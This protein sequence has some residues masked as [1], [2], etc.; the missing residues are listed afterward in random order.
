MRV[1]LLLTLVLLVNPIASMA[2]LNGD[3]HARFDQ[4]QRAL[5]GDQEAIEALSAEP[6]ERAFFHFVR[7]AALARL[8]QTD[9]AAEAFQ[10]AIRL[11][12]DLAILALAE[13]LKG[14]GRHIDAFAW[15]QVWVQSHFSLPD[16]Q[17]GKAN[18]DPGM[19]MLREL[20][21]LLDDEAI[22]EAERHAGQVLNDWLPEF[23][24]QPTSCI[25]PSLIC[26]SWSVSHRRPPR[27]PNE[28]GARG[29]EGWT[30]HALLID[31][32]GRVAEILTV[33]A[34]HAA[35]GRNAE[36]AL[37]RWRFESSADRPEPTLFQQTVLFSMR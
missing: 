28:M 15:A 3:A 27:Y 37:R 11:G 9:G 23:E 22:E 13:M 16:I 30:R 33:H 5:D 21:Q 1:F 8:E 14:A 34:T 20:L 10:R 19:A 35:A 2:E 26:P 18:R 24:M 29:D 36:R 6:E 7:G 17:Q 25:Q 32:S 31:E 4:L 12:D